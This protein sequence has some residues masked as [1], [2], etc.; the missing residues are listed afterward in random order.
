MFTPQNTGFSKLSSLNPQASPD[1]NIYQNVKELLKEKEKAKIELEKLREKE[2]ALETL[3]ENE[4]RI[5]NDNP[6]RIDDYDSDEEDFEDENNL[7]VKATLLTLD[8]SSS[9][10]IT[11]AA[12]W[13]QVSK[14]VRTFS[15]RA[16][17]MLLVLHL[18]QTS[19]CI[20]DNYV[21]TKEFENIVALIVLRFIFAIALAMILVSH[22]HIIKKK[23]KDIL[24]F[25]IFTYGMLITI[26]HASFSEKE[27]YR[28]FESI[29]LMLIYI[30]GLHAG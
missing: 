6:N 12:F 17:F 1:K 29:E 19:L 23:K 21:Y 14:N 20:A 22:S 28:K 10:K 4:E 5:R 30:I 8:L 13:E 24:C 7:F 18:L 27:I 15:L 11:K 16:I 25:V 2:A 9:S 3:E 26:L